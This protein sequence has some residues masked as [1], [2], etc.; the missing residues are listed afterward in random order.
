MG[1]AKNPDTNKPTSTFYASIFNSAGAKICESTAQM[2]YSSEPDAIYMNFAERSS[3]IV[4]N[5]ND[6]SVVL[7]FTLS[8]FVTS[9]EYLVISLPYQQ[10]LYDP[11]AT[12]VCEIKLAAVDTYT[13]TPC[14]LDTQK[15]TDYFTVSLMTTVCGTQCDDSA[16]FHVQFTGVRNP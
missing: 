13:I 2:V 3:N 1:F 16:Q 8:N 11:S 9:T 6:N 14:N 15:S 12:L 10:V 5:L 4:G 7:D